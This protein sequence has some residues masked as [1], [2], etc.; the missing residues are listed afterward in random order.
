MNGMWQPDSLTFLKAFIRNWRAVGSPLQSSGHVARNICASIDFE[1]ARTI[2]EI[3]A[4]LGRITREILRAMHP[5][6]RLI[7]FETDADLCRRLETI[8]DSRLKVYNVSGLEMHAA[9]WGKADYVI[10]EIPIANLSTP[11]QDRFYR[12]VRTVLKRGG[13][14]IQIQLSLWSY[15]RVKQYFE[16]VT[17]RFLPLNPPPVFMYCCRDR[18]ATGTHRLRPSR[19]ARHS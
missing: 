4:G 9:F 6:A 10:S 1:K 17:V 8:V 7:V 14:Y 19:V 16:D 11:L 13:C 2:V 15:R 12:E 18:R 5:H 3:G